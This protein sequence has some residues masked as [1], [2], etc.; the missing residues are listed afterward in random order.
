MNRDSARRASKAAF[1]D[2]YDAQYKLDKADVILSLDADFLSGITHPGLPQA[3]A[4]TM[5][6]AAS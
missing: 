6:S 3:G 4:R 2:F 1:G 5:Q